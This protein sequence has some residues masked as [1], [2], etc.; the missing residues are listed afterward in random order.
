MVEQHRR[1]CLRS[2][3][4]FSRGLLGAPDP[5]PPCDPMDVF[6]TLAVGQLWVSTDGASEHVHSPS[7]NKCDDRLSSALFASCLSGKPSGES[8]T[9]HSRHEC[10]PGIHQGT[11]TELD[12]LSH[13]L[14]D[15]QVVVGL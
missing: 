11:Q 2:Y 4:R 14:T 5:R 3:R 12:L 1:I 15:Y 6:H 13:M 10:L 8:G 7:D 9:R